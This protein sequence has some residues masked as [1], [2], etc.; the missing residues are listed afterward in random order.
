MPGIGRGGRVARRRAASRFVEMRKWMSSASR[1]PPCTVANNPA[2]WET[3][4]RVPTREPIHSAA[5]Y[6]AP[7]DSGTRPSARLVSR[8]SS[9]VTLQ[10]PSAS[11]RISQ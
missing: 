9:K 3:E 8:S 7:T 5:E 1:A 11:P 2:A 10:R 6:A 4:V